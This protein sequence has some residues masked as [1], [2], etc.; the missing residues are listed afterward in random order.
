MEALGTLAGGIAHDFNNILGAILGYTELTLMDLAPDSIA[1]DN[2]RAVIK[3]SHRARDLVKQILAFSRMS[4]QEHCP[5]KL[6]HLFKEA[7]RLLRASI[8][9]TITIKPMID[10][11][12]PRG[13]TILA[14]PTQIH[15]VLMNLC[16]NA[17]QAMRP[18]GGILEVGLADV[19]FS[20]QDQDRPK[21][22]PAGPYTYLWVTDS[23]PGMEAAT[24]ERIFDPFF[25]TKG[26]GE[27]T[28]MGLAVVHGIVQGHR[29]AIWVESQPGVG[30]TFKVWFP[31]L[32]AAVAEEDVELEVIAMGN[33]RI[34]LV[35]DEPPLLDAGR[36]ILQRFGYQVSPY[37]SGIEALEA[38]KAAP[39]RFDLLFTDQT[40]PQMTG[41]ELAR[42]VLALRPG[43]PI[44]LCTGFSETI[45]AESARQMGIRDL[46]T[47]PLVMTEVARVVRRV[48]DPDNSEPTN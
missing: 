14:D 5:V 40:M 36:K 29:G 48:L 44:I 43:M 30:T 16:T 46:L 13:D 33:E 37:A 23:G 32:E 12:D 41:A 17:V 4:G 18:H 25:T 11:D 7:L 27:G 8:P 34:L 38:F 3:S 39:N 47:K 9:T 2:L 19:E 45:D 1:A 6:S 22:L 24:L 28:G 20:P 21:D 35:D 15:Q 31:R 42:Q 10:L 26:V